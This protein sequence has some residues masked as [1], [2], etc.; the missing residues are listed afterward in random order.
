MNS[1]IIITLVTD[2]DCTCCDEHRV[3]YRIVKSLYCTPETRITLYVN[4]T[5]RKKKKKYLTKYE[6]IESYNI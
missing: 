1:K 2:G 6:Q 5:S 4:Y 3:V